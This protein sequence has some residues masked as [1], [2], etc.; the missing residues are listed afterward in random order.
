MNKMQLT[1]FDNGLRVASHNIEHANSLS[2]RILVKTGARDERSNEAGMAHMLEHMAFKGTDNRTAREIY[3][4]IE[5]IGGQ[6]NAYTSQEE[7]VYY[8]HL[9]NE[10]LDIG[11]DILCDIITNSNMPK[12][13]IERERGVIIQEI[14]ESLDSPEDVAYHMFAKATYGTHQLAKPILGSVDSVN[15]FTRA[16]IKGF[17]KKHYGSDRMIVA[18]AG[19][20]DHDK[21]VRGIKERLGN[22]DKVTPLKR[23]TPKW[24][25]DRCI[26][27]RD[28]EMSNVF[29]GLPCMSATDDKKIA[30]GLFSV[31]FGGGFTS[32]LFQEIRERRG[33][34]YQVYCG[35]LNFSDTG[36]FYIY[37]GTSPDKVNE[38]LKVMA[39]QMYDAANKIT[40]DELTRAKTQVRAA[41]AM[42]QDSVMN[43]CAKLTSQLSMHGR[44]FTDKEIIDKIEAVSADDIQDV[45]SGMI[46][47]GT[48]SLAVLGKDTE[49]MENEHLG[50]I[51]LTGESSS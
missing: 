50:R 37:G 47:S 19:A 5:N 30:L 33:L 49:V 31:M 27:V 43:R 26:D 36:V 12:Q 34:C 14:G 38:M 18:A 7:T 48:P 35:S 15:G 3:L 2:L 4:D 32:R 39:E 44:L 1:T 28:N 40:P 22:V 21:L 10:H 45:V 13:E 51:L 46:K 24:H 25:G 42:A 11:M 16:K 29:F 41:R 20:V 9:L 17:M 23:K 6:M 8:L